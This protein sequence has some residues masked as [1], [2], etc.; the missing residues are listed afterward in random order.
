MTGKTESADLTLVVDLGQNADSDELDRAA[1]QL[2]DELQDLNV[3]SVELAKSDVVV[4]GAKSAEVITFGSLA[5]TILPTLVPKLME[6][7][8]SWALRGESRKVKI[9]TQVGD[10]SVEVEYSPQATSQAE[11]K[12]LVETLTS[13]LETKK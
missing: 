13:A 3:G 9:K 10:R 11:L 12:D 5:I 7:L 2:R 1:R 6:F 8:Q 4:A